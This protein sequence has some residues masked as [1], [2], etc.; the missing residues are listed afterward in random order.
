MDSNHTR[1]PHLWARP[2]LL[3]PFQ[4]PPTS[5]A[6][7]RLVNLDLTRSPSPEFPMI[8]RGIRELP[9]SSASALQQGN[10]TICL[11]R[12]VGN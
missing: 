1:L 10:Y 4:T 8:G 11:A 5:G 9:R 6:L 2:N 12:A 3:T 7:E